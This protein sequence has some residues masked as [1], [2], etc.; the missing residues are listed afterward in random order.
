[1]SNGARPHPHLATA[2]DTHHTRRLQGHVQPT[3][4]RETGNLDASGIFMHDDSAATTRG[5]RVAA[6]VSQS[7]GDRRSSSDA[8]HSRP[9][10]STPSP[11]LGPPPLQNTDH[12]ATAVTDR[13][14]PYTVR[15]ELASAREL[16]LPTP[17][18]T[19]ISDEIERIT[20]RRSYRIRRRIDSTGQEQVT[21]IHIDSIEPLS[22]G[23]IV[24]PPLN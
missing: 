18:N 17:P 6:R 22:H 9:Q 16:F 11:R 13:P 12:A 23:H 19:N 1:M 7:D 2:R 21:H 24:L 10:Y 15:S 14:A 3:D 20:Q 8:V 4:R 5:R